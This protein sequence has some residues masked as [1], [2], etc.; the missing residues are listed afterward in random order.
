MKT[1]VWLFFGLPVISLGQGVTIDFENQDLTG[2]FQREEGHWCISGTDVIQGNYSLVHCFDDSIAGNDWIVFFH[3]PLA[4]SQ[5]ECIW[6]FQ[7]AFQHNPSSAN[8]WAVALASNEL[9]D[10][11]GGLANALVLGVNRVG[12]SDEFKVWQ[13]KQGIQ[14]EILNTGFNWEQHITPGERV[15]FQL[16]SRT[17]G[18]MTLSLDTSGTGFNSLCNFSWDDLS[19]VNELCI[20]Y[21]YTATHDR[22]IRFDDLVIN[23]RFA[24]DHEP[25]FVKSVEVINESRIE[26]HFSEPVILP[27]GAEWCIDQIGCLTKNGSGYDFMPLD[28]PLPVVPG[29][30]YILHIPLLTDMYGNAIQ[31]DQREISFYY[32][33]A[34]DVLITEIMA[35]PAPAVGLPE[36]EYVELYNSADHPITI[37]GWKLV[38]NSREAII[39]EAVLNA[40]S[41]LLVCD[42]GYYNGFDSSINFIALP[43]MPALSNTGATLRLQDRS[44]KLI[45][46]VQYSDNWYADDQKNDGGWSLEMIDPIDP[47]AGKTNWKASVDYR[48]GTPGKQ[49]S[50][51]NPELANHAPE[52]WR[53][54]ITDIGSVMLFFSE[55]LDSARLSNT[56]YYSVDHSFGNPNWIS[57]SWPIADKV[58]LFF[59]KEFDRGTTYEL[60]LT[61]DICDCSGIRLGP[62]ESKEYEMPLEPD[63][64][65]IVINEVMFNP[66]TDRQEFIELYNRSGK[67]IDLKDFILGVGDDPETVKIITDEYWPMAPATY[68]VIAND[69]SGIDNTDRFD[70]AE[71]IVLMDIMPMLSNEGKYLFILDKR[72]RMIDVARY[73]PDEHHEIVVDTKGVSLERGVPERSGL[74]PENWHSASSDAGFMTPAAPNSQWNREEKQVEVILSTETLTPNADG[75]DDIVTIFYHM[76]KNEYMARILVFDAEG[77]MQNTLSNGSLLGIEGCYTFDGRGADGNILPTGYYI[78]FFE[79]CHTDGDRH[80]VKKAFVVAR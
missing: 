39:P 3:E 69:Y 31:S 13:I 34:Y 50:V 36:A 38:T 73:L 14:S 19:A 75:I 28:L 29:S 78:V 60:S 71:R 66:E 72:N 80:V 42:E 30:S 16:V 63:S 9:P 41:Y 10:E 15:S 44:G 48:G 26:V 37:F 52:L 18:E 25:P 47:C 49:N 7:V 4:I 17:S 24:P 70:K 12:S 23:G 2:W 74:D 76:D 64:A 53:A 55:P 79:A 67:T 8:N 51:Y 40:G 32:P 11:K 43:D 22:G 35:D 1:L 68:A 57:A 45:H 61:S 65:D 77:R 58:E 20:L 33:R 59:D 46:A 54:A 62:G 6:Q 27:S 56:D 5:S 21:K